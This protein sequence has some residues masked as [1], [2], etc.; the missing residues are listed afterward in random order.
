LEKALSQNQ[1]FKEKDE[2]AAILKKWQS[3]Q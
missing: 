2:A 3:G 1:S